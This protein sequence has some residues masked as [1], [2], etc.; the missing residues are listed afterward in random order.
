MHLVDLVTRLLKATT[1]PTIDDDDRIILVEAAISCI[2]SDQYQKHIIECKDSSR[3]AA[4]LDAISTCRF[5]DG[6]RPPSAPGPS[7]G[8]SG[9]QPKQASP[10][11]NESWLEEREPIADEA[12]STLDS[13]GQGQQSLSRDS[14]EDD[15]STVSLLRS[16]LADAFSVLAARP[17]FLARYFCPE[18][19]HSTVDVFS[20]CLT[21]RSSSLFKQCFC[22]VIGNAGQSDDSCAALVASGVHI[23]ILDI[24]RKSNEA[25]AVHSALGATRNLAI[26]QVNKP[27]LVKDQAFV[28]LSRVWAV[29]KVP[30]DIHRLAATVGRQLVN[31]QPENAKRFVGDPDA[32]APEWMRHNAPLMHMLSAF[33][34]SEDTATRVEIGR[35]VAALLR[36]VYAK[37]YFV[38]DRNEHIQK[39][40]VGQRA[41]KTLEVLVTQPHAPVIRAEGLFALALAARSSGGCREILP[42]LLKHEVWSIVKEMM[43]TNPDDHASESVPQEAQNVAAEGKDFQEARSHSGIEGGDAKQRWQGSTDIAQ[44]TNPGPEAESANAEGESKLDSLAAPSNADLGKTMGARNRQNVQILM[45]E[46]MKHKVGCDL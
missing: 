16:S 40:W 14:I 13:G 24:I 9:R 30:P 6:D 8:D 29:P 4:L 31:L 35:V 27:V 7:S 1:I 21:V 18:K 36:T 20:E 33:D 26:P 17:E 34:G 2:A 38:S 15:Q 32:D 44:I 28:A 10:H 12:S 19:M 37:N 5:L 46:V 39:I 45:H 41:A 43:L 22:L 25:S 42:L 23:K 11:P 3:L